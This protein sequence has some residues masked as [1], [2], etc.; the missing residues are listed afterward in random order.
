MNGEKLK[1]FPLKLG[2]GKGCP[3][4]PILFNA[5]FEILAIAMRQEKERRKKKEMRQEKE[6]GLKKKANSRIIPIFR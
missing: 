5:V 6:K 4:L 3:L 2:T 1:A